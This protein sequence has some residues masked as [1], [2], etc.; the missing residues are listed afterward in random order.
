MELCFTIANLLAKSKQSRSGLDTVARKIPV[1]TP[2]KFTRIPPSS[3]LM[4]V[5]VNMQDFDRISVETELPTRTYVDYNRQ[6]PF[7]SCVSWLQNPLAHLNSQGHVCD[8]D[9]A[10]FQ[11]RSGPNLAWSSLI[12]RLEIAVSMQDLDRIS[13]EKQAFSVSRPGLD[14][15]D[16][17]EG[18][19]SVKHNST[20]IFG[21]Y[22]Q[23]KPS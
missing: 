14:C 19:A 7:W 22:N 11:Q 17:P 23:H 15:L 5:P 1:A 6:K 16:F 9:R 13:V 21:D 20:N 12:R 18:F 2:S 10:L 4:C 8:S 3:G